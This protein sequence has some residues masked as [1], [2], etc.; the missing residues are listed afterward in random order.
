MEQK[1]ML[2]HEKQEIKDLAA[3]VEAEHEAATRAK[4]EVRQFSLVLRGFLGLCLW[5]DLWFVMWRVV[6]PWLL[7][8]F[9]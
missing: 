6:W 4:E 5:G 9:C 8:S 3:R 1:Q 2:A 7:A